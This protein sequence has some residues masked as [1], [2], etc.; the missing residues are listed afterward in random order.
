M[1]DKEDVD[2]RMEKPRPSSNKNKMSSVHQMTQMPALLPASVC[3]GAPLA[4]HLVGGYLA[5]PI[6]CHRANAFS[7][8]SS[9]EFLNKGFTDFEDEKFFFE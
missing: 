9:T 1:K 6:L 2:N 7:D 3:T 8:F 5:L 4:V